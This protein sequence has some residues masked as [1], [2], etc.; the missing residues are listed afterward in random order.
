[1]AD[2]D[3]PEELRR[4]GPLWVLKL[5]TLLLLLITAGLLTQ[6][7]RSLAFPVDTLY[8]L[9]TPVA[10]A[11]FTT[12][13]ILVSW[14]VWTWRLAPSRLDYLVGERVVL[15]CVLPTVIIAILTTLPG[16][17]GDVYPAQIPGHHP[18]V[19]VPDQRPAERWGAS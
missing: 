8:H 19:E 7:I 13:G 14:L 16:P 4:P 1:M 5:E 10:V 11:C 6:G 17:G 3:A 9:D 15:W 18:A 2:Q 12:A